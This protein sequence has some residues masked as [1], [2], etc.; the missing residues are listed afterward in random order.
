MSAFAEP[1][2][3]RRLTV[4]GSEEKVHAFSHFMFESEHVL[5]VEREE[6]DP[7]RDN[8]WLLTVSLADPMDDEWFHNAAERG[9]CYIE[10]IEE[11]Y[12]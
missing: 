5:R 12:D 11:V 2:G 10:K 8:V 1:Q 3:F 4:R 7:N 9:P 6:R